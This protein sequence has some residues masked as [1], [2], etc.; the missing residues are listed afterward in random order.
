MT[1]LMSMRLT[2]MALL[3]MV[4]IA[5]CTPAPAADNSASGSHT[6]D[7]NT[8]TPAAGPTAL[9]IEKKWMGRFNVPMSEPGAPMMQY[10]KVIRSQEDFLAF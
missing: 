6:G 9:A 5:G 1:M 2:C 4:L 8:A 7:T 10:S 3:A